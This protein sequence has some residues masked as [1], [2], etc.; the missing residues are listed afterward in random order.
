MMNIDAEDLAGM[1]QAS[2]YGREGDFQQLVWLP[3]DDLP[4]IVL[5]C[6]LPYLHVS[7]GPNGHSYQQQIYYVVT[8]GA[9]NR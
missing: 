2:L 5:W 3:A 7:N 1:V 8:T 4:T 9:P 6:G